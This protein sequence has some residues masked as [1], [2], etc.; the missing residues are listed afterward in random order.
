MW[1][2]LVLPTQENQ[3]Q[4]ISWLNR[5]TALWE[6]PPT[7]NPA[8]RNYRGWRTR[9]QSWS[10]LTILVSNSRCFIQIHLL[11]VSCFCISGWDDPEKSNRATFRD[12]LKKYNTEVKHFLNETQP[13]GKRRWGQS[14]NLVHGT[15]KSWDWNT[16]NPSKVR[17]SLTYIFSYSSYQVDQ[18]FPWKQ[19]LVKCC[20][21]CHGWFEA[22]PSG[23]EMPGSNHG[24]K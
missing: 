11:L 5:S 23:G 15:P 21:C 3:P 1:L 22:A 8:L 13:S 19:H 7:T 4:W 17:F 16:Q 24:G 18:S 12:I 10:T 9:T 6:K 14:S 20:D 2:W